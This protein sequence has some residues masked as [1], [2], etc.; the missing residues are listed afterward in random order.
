VTVSD[1]R[2]CPLNGAHYLHPQKTSRVPRRYLFFDTEAHRQTVPSGERQTWRLGVSATVNWLEKS[3]KWS[4]PKFERH[5][6]PE[7]LWERILNYAGRSQRTVVVAH[8]LGYDLRISRGLALL[9]AADW[10]IEK[11][12]FSGEHVTFEANRGDLSLLFVDSHTYLPTSI[13]GLGNLL[14]VPKVLLPDEDESIGAWWSR[15]CQDVAILTRSY[16]AVVSWLDEQ[17][18]GGWA[19]TGPGTGW[20]TV[21]RRHLT[22]DVLVHNRPEVREAE[23][24][25]MYAGRCEVWQHGKLKGGPWYEWDYALAY[26]QVLESET[27]PAALV[28]QVHV[29]KYPG[30]LG[31]RPRYIHLYQAEVTTDVPVLPWSDD[32]G[33]CWPVGRFSGWYW[34]VEL[35][36]A[37]SVG[38]QVRV[39][40]AWRYRAAPWLSSWASWVKASVADDSTPEARIRGLAAKHWQRSVPGRSAMKYRSWKDSGDAWVPGVSYMPLLDL[41]TGARGAAL[42]LGSRRWEAWSTEWWDQALPQLLSSVMAHCRKRLWDALTQAGFENVVYCD[43][44]SLIV[45]RAGH[46]RLTGAVADAQLGSLRYKGEHKTLEPISP[47]LVEGST[48]RRLAGI[49]HGATRNLDGTYSGEV[50]EEMATSLAEGHPD[51]VR[52]HRRKLALTG[53]DARRLHLPGGA[54]EPFTVANGRRVAR[55]EEA[56]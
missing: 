17:D 4:E 55:E 49:P 10:R 21:L 40:R 13:G 41:D 18:L 19:R 45:N 7:N 8:N 12:T 24:A 14:G 38:A 52:I 50:W 48:Y 3:R 6:T 47:H 32:I 36:L 30:L 22:D 34:D 53:V 46:T 9:S 20:H 27:L 26:G 29:S 37:Q 39:Q 23:S 44:D 11:P 28:C 25:A 1:A 43:T 2:W 42:T 56:S 51:E 16:M 5:E 31:A 33:I 54:T 35:E 15:C